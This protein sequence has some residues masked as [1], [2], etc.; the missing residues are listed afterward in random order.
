MTKVVTI[1]LK[2]EELACCD[3][4]ARRL[5]LT[6]TDYVRYRLFHPETAA[7]ASPPGFLSRDLIGAYAVGTGSRNPQ[8]RAALARQAR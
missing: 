2:P 4:A 5:G 1:R 7:A 6:R 8:V 3:A